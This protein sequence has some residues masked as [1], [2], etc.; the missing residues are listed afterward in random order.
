M[1]LRELRLTN[2]E[3][4][5]LIMSIFDK[6]AEYED[7]KKPCVI[8]ASLNCY[9]IIKSGVNEDGFYLKNKKLADY[10]FEVMAWMHEQDRYIT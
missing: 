4:V 3:E 5:N 6:I 2:F 10:V 8:L 9:L 7:A 1:F